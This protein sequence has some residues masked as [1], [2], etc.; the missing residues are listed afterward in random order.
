MAEIKVK[1]T[2]VCDLLG[3]GAGLRH[4]CEQIIHLIG[5]FDVKL[6]GLELHPVGVLNGFSGLD[7]EQDALHLGIIPP[8][9][10]GVVG[11]GHRA[12]LMSWGRTM[13]SSSRPWS[14]SSM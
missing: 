3:V 8:Q 5:G 14:C 9:I 7:A 10:V 11:G 1:L 2:L 12:S 4:H 13:L 6:I